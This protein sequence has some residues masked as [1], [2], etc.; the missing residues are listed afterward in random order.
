MQ[1]SHHPPS[2]IPGSET[3]Q[4]IG[5]LPTGLATRSGPRPMLLLACELIAS[6][7][8][9]RAPHPLPGPATANAQW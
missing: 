6:A 4:A 7:F 8:L 9:S 5:F 2:A 1:Y 3:D